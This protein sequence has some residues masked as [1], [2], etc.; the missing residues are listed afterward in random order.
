[1]SGWARPISCRRCWRRSWRCRRPVAVPGWSGWC[2]RGRPW[3]R[4]R[5]TGSRR[6]S[7]GAGGGGVWGGGVGGG[8]GGGGGGAG[9]GRGGGGGGGVRPPRRRRRC[10][11]GQRRGQ[12]AGRLRGPGR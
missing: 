9:G 8:G 11:A 6:C 3:V 1:M 2:V 10:P 5:G 4:E 7:G 12:A